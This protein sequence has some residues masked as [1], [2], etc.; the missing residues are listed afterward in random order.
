MDR[1]QGGLGG[2][3]GE[4]GGET[5]GFGQWHLSSFMTYLYPEEIRTLVTPTLASTP[6]PNPNPSSTSL[7]SELGLPLTLIKVKGLDGRQC[8]RGNALPVIYSQVIYTI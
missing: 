3:V 8:S 6:R 2:E 1:G 4:Q 5:Q 7:V